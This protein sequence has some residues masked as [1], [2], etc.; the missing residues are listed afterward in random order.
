MKKVLSIEYLVLS[1]FILLGT[2][3]SLAQFDSTRKEI[4]LAKKCLVIEPTIRIG[5]IVRN[6][7]DFPERGAAV[8]SE[9]NITQQCSGSKKWHQ[10]M[11]YPSAG[12]ALVYG[13]MGND[14]I[15]GRNIALL[16]NLGFTTRKYKRWGFHF[17][18]GMGFAFFNKKYNRV[19]NPDNLLIG[20]T[21]T[22]MAMGSF[23]FRYD[24]SKYYTLLAGFSGIHY[25]AAHYQLPNV[26]IN[27]PTFNVSLKYFPSGRPQLYRHDS[28]PDYSRKILVNVR[29]GLG[30]H[31]FG[32][33][34]KPTN[35]AKFPVYTG[36]LYLSKRYGRISNVH[37]G[38]HINYHASFYS[39]I[40]HQEVFSK[41]QHLNAFTGQLFLGHEFIVGHFGLVTQ[42]G[43]Y[44]YNPLYWKLYETENAPANFKSFAKLYNSNKL[45]VNYYFTNPMKTTKH[46]VFIGLAL[47]ANFGQAD[48]AEMS[49]G[50]AF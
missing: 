35:G 15:I 36:S 27:F 42:L 13:I 14:D 21:M 26:G 49:V 39:F 23:D 6:F 25:S 45:G 2:T 34:I 47:K 44:F 3:E 30:F 32:G 50:C 28:L 20:T 48:F 12:V 16:P 9:I 46:N 33:S 43:I 41:N 19:S 7:P 37:L 11:G 22:N 10:L 31:E 17:K 29:L 4:P 40:T 5:K 18:I 38:V 1:I 8:L 24:I